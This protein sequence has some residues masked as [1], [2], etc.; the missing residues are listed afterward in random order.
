ME[1]SETFVTG[2]TGGLKVHCSQQCKVHADV[3][4]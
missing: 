4:T 2:N 3:P 1:N